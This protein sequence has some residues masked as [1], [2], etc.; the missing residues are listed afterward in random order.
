MTGWVS[1]VAR[2]P[3]SVSGSCAMPS[4]R[5]IVAVSKY[6][7]SQTIPLALALELEDREHPARERSAGG[8]KAPGGLPRCVPSRLNSAITASSAW[9]SA[10]AELVSLVRECRAGLLEVAHHLVGTVVHVARG[11]DLVARVIEGAE[12]HVEL[13]TVLGLH[14]LAHD[15]LATLSQ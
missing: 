13:M 12:R 7:R 5:W 4:W 11:D 14:V 2:R 9:C 3:F 1:T 8:R 15:G 6:T 10:M